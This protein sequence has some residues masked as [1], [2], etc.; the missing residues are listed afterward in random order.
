MKLPHCKNWYHL[1]QKPSMENRECRQG[2]Q[3]HNP[4]LGALP[5]LSAPRKNIVFIDF[6]F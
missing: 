1:S 2:I 4:S 5:Y 6:W 3:D